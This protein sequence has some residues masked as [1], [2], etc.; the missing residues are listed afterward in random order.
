MALSRNHVMMMVVVVVAL[1]LFVTLPCGHRV[2]AATTTASSSSLRL[3]MQSR[4]MLDSEHFAHRP[5]GVH[6]LVALLSSTILANDSS[7]QT[8]VSLAQACVVQHE[9]YHLSTGQ[10]PASVASK[11]ARSHLEVDSCMIDM[12]VDGSARALESPRNL[13]TSLSTPFPTLPLGDNAT[14]AHLQ[15]L[16]RSAS[17]LSAKVVADNEPAASAMTWLAPSPLDP[18][19]HQAVVVGLPDRQP[20]RTLR[21]TRVRVPFLPEFHQLKDLQDY[22]PAIASAPSDVQRAAL[23]VAPDPRYVWELALFGWLRVELAD[24]ATTYSN[25]LA[26]AL[27]EYSD[28]DSAVLGSATNLTRASVLLQLDMPLSI[29]PAMRDAIERVFSQRIDALID[30]SDGGL[31]LAGQGR[32]SSDPAPG[33]YTTL[34]GF[35]TLAVI[36]AALLFGGIMW[37]RG[38]CRP[39]SHLNVVPFKP[40]P[41][42]PDESDEEDQED[43]IEMLSYPDKDHAAVAVADSTNGV[44][45]IDGSD[46]HAVPAATTANTAAQ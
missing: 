41:P 10:L 39:F 40:L 33:I 7:A 34:V 30:S 13:S 3:D 38:N 35:A 28:I 32:P 17:W 37:Y 26:I 43:D 8:L 16:T 4:I 21:Q 45:Y 36:L 25:L 5:S 46:D 31:V 20:S 42:D 2:A 9:V 6:E 18:S 14:A 23:T 22:L 19:A 15:V 12:N 11:V 29:S 24:G 1:V 44:Q 27:L